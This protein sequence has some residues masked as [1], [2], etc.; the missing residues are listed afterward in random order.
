MKV[1]IFGGSGYIGT[2]LVRLL[3][4][5]YGASN[6]VVFDLIKGIVEGVEYIVSDITKKDEVK[7]AIHS[8]KPDAIV[9]LAAVHYIPYCIEHPKEVV[10][11][12]VDGVRNI[13]D[14]IKE[15]DGY[16]PRFV[17]ASSASIYGSHDKVIRENFAKIPN[18]VYGESKLHAEQVILENYSNYAL[19][20]MFNVAGNKDP[21][22]HLM[23]KVVEKALKN[24]P[25]E[26][27]NRLSKR[28]YVDVID[29]ANAY[30]LAIESK[31][32]IVCNIGT[33]VATSV[34]E[35]VDLILDKTDSKSEVSYSEPKFIRK[36]DAPLLQADISE[37]ER[38]LGW[39]PKKQLPEII[40]SA[41]KAFK[42]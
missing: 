27:G 38:V 3:I 23:P 26:L 15:V 32:T 12:N 36:A 34:E 7:K 21:N 6:V 40:E 17:F 25:I 30:I 29:V 5:R 1:L 31:D 13:L 28:D 16:S 11:I 24:E 4:E 20:R 9:N 22:P 14:S 10:K 41:I 42:V 35:L 33:N 2:E 8:H 37:A 19:L 18:D 39:K